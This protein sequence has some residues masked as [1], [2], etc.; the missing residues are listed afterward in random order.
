M[1]WTTS[2]ARRPCANSG[3]SRRD[4]QARLAAASPVDEAKIAESRA[5]EQRNRDR[6]PEIR[7]QGDELAAFLGTYRQFVE[8]KDPWTELTTHELDRLEALMREARDRFPD[9]TRYHVP[10]RMDDVR[11]LCI[12]RLITGDEAALAALPDAMLT[13]INQ[14]YRLPG[15]SQHQMFGL[16]GVQQANL[17]EHLGDI[18]LLQLGYDGMNEWRFGDMGLWQY[19]IAPQDA[20]AR[21]WEGAQLTFECA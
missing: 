15:Q 4:Y 10:V 8:G 17:Y 11:N 1:H 2:N 7:R 5:G 18:L 21:R 14:H 12:R 6:I 20:A 9:L 16:A 3:S 19:W 13:F